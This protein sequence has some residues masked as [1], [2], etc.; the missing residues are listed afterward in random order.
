[1]ERAKVKPSL[2]LNDGTV[3]TYDLIEE[4]EQGFLVYQNGYYGFCNPDGEILLEPKYRKKIIPCGRTLFIPSYTG[5]YDSL[6]LR[7]NFIT[8]DA[9]ESVTEDD[10]YIYARNSGKVTRFLRSN[11]AMIFDT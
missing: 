8:K 11:G 6:D 4:F 2:V 7:I 5:R 3:N 1:M 9:Y 10:H